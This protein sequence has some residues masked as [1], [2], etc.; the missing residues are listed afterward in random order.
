MGRLLGIP[1]PK[2]RSGRLPGHEP[3]ASGAQSGDRRDLFLGG[4]EPREDPGGVPHQCLTGLGQPHLAA[5]ADEQGGAHGGLQGLHLLADGG[6]GA[7]QLAARRRE[8]SG[9]GDGAQDTEM[10]GL[11][12]SPSIREPW[13]QREIMRRRFGALSLSVPS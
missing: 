8:G 6:L 12:H 5:R 13:M 11:D 1:G 3:Y 2:T 9:G 4:G 7:A 10:T